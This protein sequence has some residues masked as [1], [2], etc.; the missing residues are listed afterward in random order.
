[1]W[2]RRACRPASPGHSVLGAP[3]APTL[4]SPAPRQR[5]P[6]PLSTGLKGWAF[7]G[8]K[9]AAGR[10]TCAPPS[11]PPPP[12]AAPAP[13]YRTLPRYPPSQGPQTHTGRQQE[14]GPWQGAGRA[15]RYV[16][17]C[18]RRSELSHLVEALHL[19]LVGGGVVQARQQLRNHAVGVGHCA[20]LHA[21]PVGVQGARGARPG[22]SS[23]GG[24]GG[25]AGGWWTGGVCQGCGACLASGSSTGSPPRYGN[26][27]VRAGNRDVGGGT[28]ALYREMCT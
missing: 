6:S 25:A 22:N 7:V 9:A 2:P 27:R 24:G 19:D 14:H 11:R 21:W 16:V 13:L 4:T 5:V 20:A 26:G 28:S 3:P 1:M 17:G 8:P 12:L 23:F 10:V 15:W 18:T